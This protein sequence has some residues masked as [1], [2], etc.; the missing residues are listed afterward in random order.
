MPSPTWV[1]ASPGTRFQFQIH[2]TLISQQRAQALQAPV[3]IHP[4]QS[5]CQQGSHH[6][7]RL[8]TAASRPQQQTQRPPTSP[9][10]STRD[11]GLPHKRPCSQRRRRWAAARCWRGPAPLDALQHGGRRAWPPGQWRS[12]S[13]LL[14]CPSSATLITCRSGAVRAGGTTPRCSS[15]TTPARCAAA[16][17]PPLPAATRCGSSNT[18]PTPVGVLRGAPALASWM[19]ARKMHA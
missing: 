17:A 18:R 14:L 16:G 15:P 7:S 10:C 6:A 11:C 5:P 8:R 19:H 9:C 4:G 2:N 12:P 1:L 13:L 3:S